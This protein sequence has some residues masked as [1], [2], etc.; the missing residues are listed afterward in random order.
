MRPCD[1]WNASHIATCA[2]CAG[3]K[4]HPAT[5]RDLASCPSPPPAFAKRVR[6]GRARDMPRHDDRHVDA[7]PPSPVQRPR[8]MSG[9][10]LRQIPAE[11]MR[12]PPDRAICAARSDL[13]RRFDRRSGWSPSPALTGCSLVQRRGRWPGFAAVASQIWTVSMSG[14]AARPVR[15][16]WVVVRGP[17]GQGGP[18]YHFRPAPEAARAITRVQSAGPV[19]TIRDR[20]AE[21]WRPSRF[22]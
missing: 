7:L 17:Y 18:G 11:S 1:L 9:D 15:L 6:R 3:P 2:I 22:S 5:M 16:S 12:G 20:A 10:A 21:S 19:A 4:R 13:S 8:S 14:R